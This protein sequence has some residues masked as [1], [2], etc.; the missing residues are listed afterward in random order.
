MIVFETEDG[1]TIEV[2]AAAFK[3]VSLLVY[4][5]SEGGGLTYM[6]IDE[7]LRLIDGLQKAIGWH[8]DYPG[9]Q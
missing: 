6:T 5:T 9:G 7:A 4:T 1:K 8:H 3:K 2:E